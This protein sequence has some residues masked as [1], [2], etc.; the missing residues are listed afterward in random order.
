MKW[1]KL[2][3][4]LKKDWEKLLDATEGFGKKAGAKVRDMWRDSESMRK[5]AVT[6]SRKSAARTANGAKW[7]GNKSM[8]QAGT[9]GAFLSQPEM[10]KWLE[11]LTKAPATIYDKAMDSE[12]LRTHIGGGSHRMFDGG[13][14]PTD[15]WDRASG[16]SDA[17]TFAQEVVGYVSGLWKDLSTVSGLPF[18]TWDKAD[19]DKWAEVAATHIPGADK[20]YFYDLLSFDAFEV[21][22]TGLGAVGVVFALKADD[23]KRLSEILGSMGI[24]SI[25]S[26]NPLMGLAVIATTGYAYFVK[27]RE[28]DGKALL[29]GGVMATTSM[30]VFAVLGLPL[31]VELVIAMVVAALVKKYVL[32]RDDV[33]DM[34]ITRTGEVGAAALEKL[35]SAF[36]KTPQHG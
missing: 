5:S 36:G 28:V 35:K 32:S 1:S 31:L 16:A 27:K 9:I 23:K 8:E 20:G 7:L 6:Y 10:L 30:A 12:Y 22:S 26:A 15:A 3:E 29:K 13:H 14:S 2:K 11:N 33:A 21:L 24:I 19:Y 18:G 17:D 4:D 25:L 34:V